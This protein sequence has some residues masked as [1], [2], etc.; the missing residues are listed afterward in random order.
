MARLQRV[1]NTL[2]TALATVA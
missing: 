2:A 1:H